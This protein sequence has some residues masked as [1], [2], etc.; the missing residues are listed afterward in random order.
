MYF[1]YRHCGS[2]HIGRWN[3]WA[4]KPDALQAPR[5]LCLCALCGSEIV[6]VWREKKL[7]EEMV[8]LRKK[9]ELNEVEKQHMNC[10]WRIKGGSVKRTKVTLT[11]W[12]WRKNDKT[13][14]PIAHV[15][16][17]LKSIVLIT[18][19]QKFFSNCM[20]SC[21]ADVLCKANQKKKILLS[22]Y[23][24]LHILLL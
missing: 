7:L 22:I 23:V 15:V 24:Q 19:R 4:W 6:K 5:T 10:S 17:Y 16:S 18:T 12:E 3:I 2:K 13:Q 8:R 1:V 14:K 20:V 21:F 11:R 9:S